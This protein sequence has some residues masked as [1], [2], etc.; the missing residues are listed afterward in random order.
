MTR[1]HKLALVVGFGLILFVGILLSDHLRQGNRDQKTLPTAAASTLWTMPDTLDPREPTRLRDSRSNQ[2]A[3]T[4]VAAISVPTPTQPSTTIDV[5]APAVLTLEPAQDRE[6]TTLLSAQRQQSPA[7]PA[8]PRAP[9]SGSHTVGDGET[10]QD[11]SKIHFGTT[12]RWNEIA[13][14]NNIK[15]PARI[16]KGMQLRLPGIETTRPV[17]T[18][19]AKTTRTASRSYEVQDGDT[20]IAIA[21][22]TLGSTTRWVDI[23]KLNNI[24]GPSDIQPGQSLKLPAR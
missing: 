19:P 22:K 9:A 16:R 23:Q 12:R 10:L 6:R 15:N 2:P 8:V 1:E 11:I 7:E 21:Q 20:L 24:S 3:K 14:I 17:P 5:D 18:Q 13:R 4:E